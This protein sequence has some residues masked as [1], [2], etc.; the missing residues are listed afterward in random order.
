MKEMNDEHGNVR[1]NKIFEWML[2]TF[3]GESFYEC[4][5]ARMRNYMAHSITSKG[6]MPC[7]Y[8]PANGKVI[9]ADYVA[10]FF[11]CQIARS[12]RG[13]P[14][15]SCT[16]LTCEPLDAISMYMESMPKMAFR[17][18]YH[19]LH[20]DNDWDEDDKWDEVYMDQKQSSPENTAHHRQKFSMFKDGF[21]RWWKE[22]LI[23]RCWLTFDES[24]VAGWYHSPIT[25]GPDPKPIHTG[26]T[27]HSL[28][29]MHGDLTLYKVHVCMFGRA[30]DKDLAKQ[31]ENT[32]TTQKWVNLL[33]ID[34]KQL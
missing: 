8:C 28:A 2:P 4:L 13:N 18:I 31:N 24:R 3:D 6:W 15:I 33:L 19:C 30:T 10:H 5:S 11:G 21:N 20:F 26:T 14:S 32:V 7:Y 23:F 16:W 27:I 9:V 22:C 29:I 34:A 25:Q 17:D 12:L 1:F